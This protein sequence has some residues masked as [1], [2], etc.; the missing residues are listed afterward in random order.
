MP[1]TLENKTEEHENHLK[2]IQKVLF[3]RLKDIDGF[4]EED[5]LQLEFAA[6]L[7]NK[8]GKGDMEK[9]IKLYEAHKKKSFWKRKRIS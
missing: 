2:E 4:V 7:V 9:Y 1:N 8:Y 6:K 5:D 3:E